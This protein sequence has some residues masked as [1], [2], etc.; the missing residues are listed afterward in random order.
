MELH[1]FEASSFISKDSICGGDFFNG[2]ASSDTQKKTAIGTVKAATGALGFTEEHPNRPDPLVI[3]TGHPFPLLP[4]AHLPLH[5]L[6]P[7]TA[8]L[9]HCPAHPAIVI[10]HNHQSLNLVH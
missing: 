3:T 10:L 4:D 5:Y 7:S 9:L 2:S 1:L 8:G 6:A